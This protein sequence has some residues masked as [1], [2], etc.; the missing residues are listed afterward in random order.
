MK[1][2]WIG[3]LTAALL[4]ACGTGA[5]ES[6]NAEK[7]TLTV[8]AAASLTESFGALEKRFEAEHPD[9]DVKPNYD[10]SSKLV[11]QITEGA[12]AD[13]FAS[14]DERNMA[15]AIDA[16]R[17]EG[18]PAPF[19][20]NRLTIAVA[21]GNPRQIHGLADLTGQDK[22]VVTCAPQVPCGAAT[23]KAEQAAGLTLRPASE[24]RN[25]KSVLTKVQAGAADAGLVYVTDARSAGDAAQAVDFPESAQAIN[26]YPIAGLKDAPQPE[27]ARQFIDFV[28]GPAG[29]QE[30]A[31]VGF[32]A[33]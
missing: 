33:P 20:T 31:K 16:G 4:T 11:Q 19:A 3:V 32:G 24:E 30:L 5:G 23:Q 2:I 28:L 8:F 29:R 14:A 6:A 9:V 1:R 17:V 12:G 22:T 21:P 15:K 10:G 25:V 7:K 13:V 18:Q 27:L 26:S